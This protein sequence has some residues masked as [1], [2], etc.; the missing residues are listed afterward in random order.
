MFA[1]ID[2]THLYYFLKKTSVSWGNLGP[3]ILL[4]DYK[5]YIIGIFGFTLSGLGQLHIKIPLLMT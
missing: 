4:W 1:K 5:K 2:Y 3:I